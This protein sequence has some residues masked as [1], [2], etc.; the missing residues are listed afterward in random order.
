MELVIVLTVLIS[1]A[2]LL[3]PVL[4][5]GGLQARSVLC[6]GNQGKLGTWASMYM[7]DTKGFLPPYES[8]WVERLANFG[9]K[10]VAPGQAP[11]GEFAC[12]SQPHTSPQSRLSADEYW[13]G[14]HYGLNQ[15]LCSGLLNRFRE[16]FG[17]WG[18]MNASQLKDPSLKLLLADASGMNFFLTPGRDPVV[19]G[20]SQE[21][22]TY[23]ESLPERPARPFPYLR[24]LDGT[25][26]FLFMDGH[27][28]VRS[29][30]PAFMLGPGTS[31]YDF[32]HAEHWYPGCGTERPVDEA[33]DR[34]TP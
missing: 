28:E 16:P 20:L 24:H 3:L 12:P 8:G 22:V 29:S 15:H 7:A 11:Q 30:W 4:Y 14:T 5:R 18:M 9:G 32:W 10:S 26:N 27:G 23:A 33:G 19:A 17:E 34:S 1:L 25:G 13:R 2:S 31:G 6:A 21:G